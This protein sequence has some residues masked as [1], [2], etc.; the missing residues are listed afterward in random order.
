MRFLLLLL[1]AAAVVAVIVV[2]RRRMAA[3]RRPG[4]RQDPLRDVADR[5]LDTIGVGGVV[6]HGGQDHVVRGTLS[7]DQDGFTWVEHLLAD[8][9][10]KRWLSVED[11]EGIEVAM[12]EA[13]PLADVTTGQPGDREVVIRGTAYRLDEKGTARFT[14]EGTTGT[15]P[16]GTVDYADYEGSTG[17]A[18]FERYGGGSWEAALGSRITPGELTIYAAPRD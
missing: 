14:A 15:A 5:E 10:V 7:F 11:D 18:S 12:W 6:A 1:L 8:V 13:V 16:T 9:G 17:L 2:V 4:P 3:S